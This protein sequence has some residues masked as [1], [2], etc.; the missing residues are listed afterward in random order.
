VSDDSDTPQ[1]ICPT[2]E[3]VDGPWHSWRFDG[4]DPRVICAYC[5]E[6][7][8]A[9]TGNVIRSGHSEQEA[10]PSNRCICDPLRGITCATHAEQA[11][12]A[13]A[14][15]PVVD[16]TAARD[17]GWVRLA[18]VL[19]ALR[20]EAAYE[21]FADTHA[22]EDDGWWVDRVDRERIAQFLAERF[23]REAM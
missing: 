9:L 4:D 15:T 14:G 19:D 20:D 11:R 2:S 12:A 22:R 8:D 13:A 7:R 23:G 1:D 10:R 18:E 16:E 5:G 21:T 17:A 3:R 6:M